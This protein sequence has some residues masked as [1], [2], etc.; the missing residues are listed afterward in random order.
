MRRVLVTGGTTRLGAHI[1]ARLRTDGW[2]VL[3]SSHRADAGADW[4][5]DLTQAAAVDQLFAVCGHLDALVNNASLFRGARE[6]LTALNVAAP[7]RLMELMAAHGGA[8]VNIL[9]T[10][11][12]GGRPATDDYARSKGE[13]LRLTERFARASRPDFRVN[14]V[15]PGPVLVPV[16]VPERAGRLLTRRPSPEDVASAVAFLLNTPSVTGCILPVDGGQHLLDR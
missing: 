13:L 3:T 7:G 4:V 8:V 2:Q 11:V 14:A 15:A 1:A 16:G 12:L 10:R 5:A 6:R 9:D